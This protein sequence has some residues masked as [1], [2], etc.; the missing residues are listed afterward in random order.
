MNPKDTLNLLAKNTT[1]YQSF[2]G[3][4]KKNQLKVTWEIFRSQVQI[5]FSKKF[6]WAMAVVLGYF[7]TIYFTNYFEE[8]HERMELED[9]LWFLQWPLC[10]LALY[11]N[12]QLIS[13]EKE[14]RTLEVLFTTAGSRY[15]VWLLRVGTLNLILL[16]VAFSLSC[17]TF[18][19]FS[20]LPILT[21]AM[22]SFVPGF[23]TGAV[24][25]YL[26]VKFRSGFAAAMVTILFL[27]LNIM[28]F[29]AL[30]DTRYPLFF[31]YYD[32]PHNIDPGTWYLWMWQNRITI[33]VLAVLLQF[34]TLR[35]LQ[36]RERLLR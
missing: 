18:F 24:T 21:M 1:I 12:M 2:S 30:Q 7:I 9:L 16:L 22:N 31:N 32:I 14:N 29:S 10:G 6:T 35:G 17:L 28:F 20:D 27:L 36:A 5:I 13:S 8:I 33:M 11:L 3:L 23:F 19:T 25:L 15:K 34:F 4:T 26:S